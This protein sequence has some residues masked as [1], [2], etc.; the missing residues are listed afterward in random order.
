MIPTFGY[1]NQ[2]TGRN[3]VFDKSVK[4]KQRARSA[5]T[6]DP[7][8][9]DYIREEVADRLADRLNDISRLSL[10]YLCS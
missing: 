8:M 2:F 6:D 5:L 10:F 3:V 9:Y 4:E 1:R 7:H